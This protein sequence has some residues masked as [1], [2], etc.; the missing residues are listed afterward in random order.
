MRTINSRIT[1]SAVTGIS[2]G[3]YLA[4]M[5]MQPTILGNIGLSDLVMRL[6]GSR[7]RDFRL[8]L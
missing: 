1:V 8:L 4:V 7:R 3:I 2:G 5:Y 6:S